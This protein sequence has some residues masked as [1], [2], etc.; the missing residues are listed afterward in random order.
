MLKNGRINIAGINSIALTK[1][2]VLDNFKNIKIC[3]QYKLGKKNINFMPNSNKTLNNIK[4]KYLTLEGWNANTTGVKNR[5]S[6]PLKARR[7]I[8]VIE[9]LLNIPIVFLSNGP[10]RNDIIN[11]KK[12]N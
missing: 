5:S 9:K 3:Y 7:F 4:P 1:I 12:G 11:L 2:D 10:D 8:N 6:L